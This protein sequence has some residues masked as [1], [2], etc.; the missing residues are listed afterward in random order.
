MG[1]GGAHPLGWAAGGAAFDNLT[2]AVSMG[3]LCGTNVVVPLSSPAPRPLALSLALAALLLPL[4]S[5]EAIEYQSGPL[6]HEVEQ[7]PVPVSTPG[8][9]IPET[10]QASPCDE[11]TVVGRVERRTPEV[12]PITEST[13][14]LPVPAF[15]LPPDGVL[16]PVVCGD[17]TE[18]NP[19]TVGPT[20]YVAPK[21]VGAGPYTVPAACDVTGQVCVGPFEVEG[22]TL[23]TTPVVAFSFDTPGLAAG[24]DAHAG[25][26]VPVGPVPVAV[27][28]T[29]LTTG[30][31]FTV[32]PQTCP[33]QRGPS[34]G[35]AW[36]LT[37]S[38]QVGDR[39]DSVT[40]PILQ[41][42]PEVLA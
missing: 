21:T 37:V 8:F 40:V 34:G 24:A 20:P 41:V 19:V 25:E 15:C 6:G 28:D 14:P 31:T 7:G 39:S 4:A 23:A 13:P 22:M 12:S 27:P 33:V 35:V 16:F 30:G 3:P 17:G 29:P 32:C 5:A 26:T 9:T 1:S 18:V 11:D 2:R 38:W 36:T 42:L 10:C